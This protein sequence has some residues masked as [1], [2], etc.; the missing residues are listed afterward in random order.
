MNQSQTLAQLIE[1]A[2]VALEA[3]RRQLRP[4]LQ[5]A[6][7]RKQN[8]KQ[9]E[10]TEKDLQRILVPLFEKQINR[11][12]A[13]L[14]SIGSKSA[15]T[16]K[17][18]ATLI[19]KVFDQEQ[20]TEELIDSVMP[21]LA[22]RMAEAARNQVISL[23]IDPRRKRKELNTRQVKT[24]TATEWLTE[25]PEDVAKLEEM[26]AG[27]GMPYQVFTE[28]PVWMK[29][30]IVK[31]LNQSFKQDYWAKIS[32]STAGDAEMWL[33]RGLQEGW[34]IRD[35][36]QRMAYSFQEET[37][38]Y[39][40]RRSENIART[41]CLPGNTVVDGANVLAAH[42][43]FYSGPLVEVITKAGRKF[44]GT[45][46]HPML[47]TRGW[48]PIGKLTEAD[49]LIC[50][51]TG[52]DQ[53]STPGNVDVDN[54]PIT[55]EQIFDSL[56]TVGIVERRTTTN[57]DFHGDGMDGYVDIFYTN[58]L[59][60]Y[61]RETP[62]DKLV[63]DGVLAEAYVSKHCLPMDSAS[64]HTLIP[65]EDSG[66]FN[67]SQLSTRFDDDSLDTGW[68]D[69]K[70][71]CDVRTGFTGTVP[72]D[73]L[74]FG[75]VLSVGPVSCSEHQSSSV[76]ECTPRNSG[77]FTR[78][79]DGSFLAPDECGNFDAAH[80]GQIEIDN[81][82]I[83]RRIESWSGHVFNL[84]TRDGYFIIAD[85]VYTG[86]SGNALNGARKGVMDQLQAD[87]G[88]RVPMKAIWMSVLGNT[89]RDTH[90]ALDGV[91]ADK[92]GL[93]YL[94]GMMVPWPGHYSLPA[95]ERCQCQCSIYT[96]LGMLDAEALQLIQ[97]YNDSGE[98]YEESLETLIEK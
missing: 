31:N 87:L 37:G 79:E 43:R 93:W 52:D 68:I 94:G 98:L 64:N 82:L 40:L 29:K 88:D 6:V 72:S 92:N 19:G 16:E 35:M 66:F 55:I 83:L 32:E 89:T 38:K 14:K 7:L 15:E 10:V 20:A 25:H 3:K 13:G 5:I 90:A 78:S 39:A 73:D 28:L 11:I 8:L 69:V 76:L 54:P 84:T 30:D 12:A 33:E 85:G 49:D 21:I 50:H 81:L 1:A 36:A 45:P 95:G 56:S 62:L 41:E 42:R 60:S 51:K 26:L 44:T 63:V 71:G 91:P 86:N 4:I 2:T 70:Q 65:T 17:S 48:V 9:A 18:A 24:T 27:L 96:E 97:E 59:L 74:I 58:G 57:V 80:T 77:T 47:T 75:Q 53:S 22:V 67:S 46:N 23:G 61:G 34:S